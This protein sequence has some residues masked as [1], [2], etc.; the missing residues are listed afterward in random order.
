MVI[1]TQGQALMV[2]MEMERRSIRIY[3]RA[4]LLTEGETRA[5]AAAILREEKRH[6]ARFQEM[7]DRTQPSAEDTVLLQALA[8]EVLLPGGVME[9][10]REEALNSARELAAYAAECEA[11]AVKRY[12]ELAKVC[13]GE[14][15]EAFLSIVREEA[16]HLAELKHRLSAHDDQEPENGL[17]ASST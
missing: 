3:E 9:L 2:A 11:G 8:A 1:A 4:L 5:E 12:A 14:A 17:A 7:W 13:A 10:K 6:L 16:G 15:R